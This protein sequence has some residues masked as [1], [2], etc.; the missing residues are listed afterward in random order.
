MSKIGYLFVNLGSPDSPEVPDVRRYLAQFLMDKYVI[1]VPLILRFFVVY[2]FV[3]PFRPK[4][5]AE[6]YST[7]WTDED[8][9]Y[10]DVKACF[11]IV[12]RTLKSPWHLV[13]AMVIHRLN[14]P[15]I[16]Y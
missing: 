11:W 12:K 2:C 13:C 4:K 14:Q 6:A 5:S 8:L 15:L 10:C 3:L 1:D 7:I 9:L 16:R